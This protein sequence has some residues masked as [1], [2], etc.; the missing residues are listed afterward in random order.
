MFDK[1]KINEKE[2]G[3]GPFFLIVQSRMSV[4]CNSFTTKFKE[5]ADYFVSMQIVI[6]P[7]NF[8]VA[9]AGPEPMS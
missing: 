5:K 4:G 1:T 6:T 7:I 2:A 9:R 3:V 8:R